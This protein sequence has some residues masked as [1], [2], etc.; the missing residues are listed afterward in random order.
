MPIKVAVLGSTGLVGRVLVDQLADCEGVCHVTAITRRATSWSSPKVQVKVIDFDEMAENADVF[1]VD[2]VFLCLGT[3][4]S[5]AGSIAAQRR[6]DVDYQYE[7]AQL[8]HER[9][10]PHVLL[11]SSSGANARSLSPYLAMK[12]ELE[13]RLEALNFQHLTILQPSL[14][15]GERDRPRFAEGI[16]AAVLPWVCRLPVLTRFRPIEGEVVARRLLQEAL[17]PR[18]G[19]TRLRLDEVFL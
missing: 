5:Q 14:L 9:G 6:V 2:A 12:G 17:A 13:E 1:D 15:L 7:A 11:V 16:G 10:V 4:L 8:A 19:V 18:S 3:T